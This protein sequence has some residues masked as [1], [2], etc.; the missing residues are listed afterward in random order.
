MVE[1]CFKNAIESPESVVF[2]TASISRE[3]AGQ[4]RQLLYDNSVTTRRYQ[5]LGDFIAEDRRRKETLGKVF[6][7]NA[8]PYLFL[9]AGVEIGIYP[10]W[11]KLVDDILKHCGEEKTIEGQHETQ[12]QRAQRAK[13]SNPQKY[14]QAV[15]NTF[16][17]WQNLEQHIVKELGKLRLL[18]VITTNYNPNLIHTFSALNLKESVLSNVYGDYTKPDEDRTPRVYY[19]HGIIHEHQIAS[20]ELK[21]IL[22][23]S[24]YDEYYREDDSISNF[25]QMVF[26][27]QRVVFIATGLTDDDP[28]VEILRKAK[29]VKQSE[30]YPPQDSENQRLFV[31][32]PMPIEELNGSLVIK[33]DE[34]NETEEKYED[35]GLVPIWYD[36][37]D[38]HRHLYEIVQSLASEQPGI[39]ESGGEPPLTP[40]TR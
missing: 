17:S 16:A 1:G 32:L 22:A 21:I 34:I 5:T 25:L 8:P 4:P 15:I 31:F 40:S 29:K 13:N 18:G 2:K 14:N 9:G 7:G 36:K 20:D 28:F 6:R 33:L 26:R 35:I 3:I 38:N 30:S 23:E 19:I 24:D 11:E 27:T 39:K 37:L 12:P 10:G